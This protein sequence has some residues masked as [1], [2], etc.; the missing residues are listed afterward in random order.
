[1]CYFQVTILS[2][3]KSLHVWLL[4]V[5]RLVQQH[6]LMPGLKEMICIVR[7]QVLVLNYHMNN[8]VSLMNMDIK[9]LQNTKHH[10]PRVYQ[11]AT[12]APRA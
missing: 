2:P 7:W 3:N 4:S 8:A 6:Y 9:T 10:T 11:H 5:N 1:M 12:R